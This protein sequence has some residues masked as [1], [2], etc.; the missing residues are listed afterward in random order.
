MFVKNDDDTKMEEGEYFAIETFGSTGRGRVV[1]QVNLSVGLFLRLLTFVRVIARIMQR[2]RTGPE[3]HYGEEYA[4]VSLVKID[5][6]CRLTTAK[7]LLKTINNQF[8][9][10]AFCRR[11]LDRIGETKYLLA[12]RSN[13]PPPS[14]D[15]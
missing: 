3:C 8:G 7:S 2:S 9:T 12:V 4:E 13:R 5:T 15:H 1:E 10:L 6:L 14:I 11:Y